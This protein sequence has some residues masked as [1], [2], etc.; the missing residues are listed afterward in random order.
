MNLENPAEKQLVPTIFLD[1]EGNSICNP[2]ISEV[3]PENN[4]MEAIRDSCVINGHQ[5]G[6]SH[7]GLLVTGIDD[8]RGHF[9]VVVVRDSTLECPKTSLV[10]CSMVGVTAIAVIE[11]RSG[12]CLYCHPDHL[13][14]ES[15]F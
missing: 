11:C 5:L 12:Q 10:Q 3:S 14:R 6:V 7:S 13:P 2:L 15:D 1:K 9:H 8:H 4:A